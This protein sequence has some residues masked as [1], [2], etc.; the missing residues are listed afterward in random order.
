MVLEAGLTITLVDT[1][2]GGWCSSGHN[3]PPFLKNGG[4]DG[5]EEPTKFYSIKN[6]N[7]NGIYCEVCLKVAQQMAKKATKK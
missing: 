4:A 2:S 6:K 3:A 7:I 5:P 1:P